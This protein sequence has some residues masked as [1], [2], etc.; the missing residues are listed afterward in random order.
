MRPD[1]FEVLRD[2]RKPHECWPW[3]GCRHPTLGYGFFRGD[4]AHR[5]AYRR[6]YGPIPNGMCVCHRCDNPECCNPAHLFVGTHRDN[7]QDSIRKGRFFRNRKLRHA[8]SGNR[9]MR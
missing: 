1:A 2:K 3:T 5:E 7:I 9:A 4:Y 8:S 6:A